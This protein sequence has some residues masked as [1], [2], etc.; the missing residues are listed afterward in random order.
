MVSWA[1]LYDWRYR[2]S[3]MQHRMFIHCGYLLYHRLFRE[4]LAVYHTRIC[5]RCRS[6]LCPQC[7][8]LFRDRDFI[9]RRLLC[10]RHL[11]L[12][13]Y[14]LRRAISSIF[15]I[16]IATIFIT[17]DVALQIP[18]GGLK[19]VVNENLVMKSLDLRLLKLT[20]CDY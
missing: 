18:V 10:I 16:L 14:D 15:R 7:W 17:K 2:E 3:I 20:L 8:R 1:L 5:L 12:S 13:V 9:L 11:H 6:A 4:V 19:I